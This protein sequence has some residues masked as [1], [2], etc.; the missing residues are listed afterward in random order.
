MFLHCALYGGRMFS[1]DTNASKGSFLKSVINESMCKILKVDINKIWEFIS[2]ES[3]DK[4]VGLRV[5]KELKLKADF[6]FFDSLH[7]LDH[8]MSEIKSFEIVNNKEFVIALDDAYYTKKS[9]NFSYL[10]MIRQKLNLNKIKEPKSNQCGPFY[11][12]VKNYLKK[13]Y[14]KVL[15]LN[16]Y[17][18]KNFKGDIFFSYFESD[19]IFLNKTGMEDKS[20]LK[21]RLEAFLIKK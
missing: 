17:Y 3:T 15:H 9:K 8:L 19:R 6:C 7:T 14:R 20:K 18:Q 21:N 2:Y 1:W 4:F 10:N 12:E 5:L 11:S 13:R 16:N